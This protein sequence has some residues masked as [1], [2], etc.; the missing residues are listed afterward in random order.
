MIYGRGNLDLRSRHG[1]ERK[2][3]IVLEIYMYVFIALVNHLT[4]LNRHIVFWSGYL[5]WLHKHLNRN[6]P[7]VEWN[8]EPFHV[9]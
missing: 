5:L 3:R 4:D 7:S 6:R 2:K 8:E 1:I 9:K